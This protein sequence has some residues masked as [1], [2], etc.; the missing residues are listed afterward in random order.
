MTKPV[1]PVNELHLILQE[2]K[3]GKAS[4]QRALFDLMGP[5]MLSICRRYCANDDD[6]CDALQDGFVKV[7]MQLDRFKGESKPE[8]WMTRIFMNTAIDQFKKS[9]R[10]L[11][12]DQDH[13]VF[14]NE[15]Y[16]GFEDELEPELTAEQALEALDQLPAGYRIVFN[17][18]VLEGIPHK[19]IAARLGISEGTSKSQLARARQHL[20]KILTGKTVTKVDGQG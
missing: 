10:F 9:S 1:N 5:R 15:D 20:C 17:M 16:A 6:A 7:F 8:T 3:N 18:Y 12:F 11:L 14:E 2:C 19:E 4:A 13:Q